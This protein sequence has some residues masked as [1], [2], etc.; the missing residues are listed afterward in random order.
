MVRLL[1][2][3][4]GANCG[5]SQT[6]LLGIRQ[7]RGNYV[8]FLDADDCFL[9]GKL[10]RQLGTMEEYPEVVLCHSAAALLN[11][12]LKGVKALTA[13]KQGFDP[14]AEDRL[15]LLLEQ[16]YRLRSCPICN[17]SIL[18]R[19]ELLLSAFRAI[20][21]A[22]QCEDW[23]T[24]CLLAQKGPFY[25]LNEPL[26]EY[27]IHEES[28]T[29][30]NSRDQLKQTF[31]T[32][33]FYASLSVLATDQKLRREASEGLIEKINLLRQIY[34]QGDEVKAFATDQEID[35]DAW[36]SKLAWERDVVRERLKCMNSNVW[37]RLLRRL[38]LLSD[39]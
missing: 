21:Q 20:P 27:R 9:P 39:A 22:Y 31:G 35:L 30:Q 38:K 19:R 16:D 13:R 8:A 33:E 11:E 36:H 1:E 12:N 34:A 29:E 32:I 7:A 14:F 25:Y 3:P 5:V 4:N 10:V 37:V 15:Y 28:Y 6:R 26:V 17:S 24:A 23:L 2:H 18:V